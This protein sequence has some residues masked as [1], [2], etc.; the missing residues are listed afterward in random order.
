[1]KKEEQLHQ[2]IRSL[3]PAEKKII[4]INLSKFRPNEASK[5][6]LLFD[7]LNAQKKYSSGQTKKE[8]ENADNIIK[9][10]N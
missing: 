1:M 10:K 2:L 3:T 4:K 7:S 6:L 9:N 8:F 5:K